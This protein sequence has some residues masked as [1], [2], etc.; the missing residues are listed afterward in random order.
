MDMNAQPT[1]V[2]LAALTLAALGQ[3]G[4]KPSLRATWDMPAHCDP[5]TSPTIQDLKDE[6][7]Q[8][9]YRL[10]IAIHPDKPPDSKGEYPPRDLY[11]INADGS[12]LKQLTDTPDQEE[13][14][15]R[16]SPDGKWFTCN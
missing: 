13:R 2:L 15:P 7:R 14:A 11:V 16:V 6:L 9:G 4:E 10:V 5:F 3:A 1:L 8:T 12:G